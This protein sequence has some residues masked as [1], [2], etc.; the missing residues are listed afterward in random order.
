MVFRVTPSSSAKISRALMVLPVL[1]LA[2]LMAPTTLS[3]MGAARISGLS[4]VALQQQLEEEMLQN[5]TYPE[6]LEAA[7]QVFYALPERADLAIFALQ[8]SLEFENRDGA[9]WAR[10]AYAHAANSEGWTD[11]ASHA[12]AES[13][14][15]MPYADREFMFWRLRLAEFYWR[16]LPDSLKGLVLREARLAPAPWRRTYTPAIQAG[17]ADSSAG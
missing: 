10:L 4:H 1:L 15:R 9:I 7:D 14:L 11:D 17:L 8:R 2:V 3:F 12:L 13:Y 6:L 5:L 16:D